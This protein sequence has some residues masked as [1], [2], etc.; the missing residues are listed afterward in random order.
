MQGIVDNVQWRNPHVY[1]TISGVSDSGEQAK[2]RIEAGPT[3]IMR[4]L[5]WDRDTLQAGDVIKVTAN[6]SRREGARSGYLVSVEAPG[7]VYPSLRGDDAM[8]RLAEG[9]STSAT[10]SSI[11]GTWTTV[12]N[13]EFYGKIF[14][15]E[16]LPLTEA[17]LASKESFDELTD[18]PGLDCIPNV[19][20]GMMWIPDIK[21]I[22]IDGDEI[23]IRGEFA[24]GERVIYLDPDAAP[25]GPTLHGR[26]VG[27]W[28]D[29]TLVVESDLFAHHRTG[30]V[31]SVASSPRKNVTETFR[32]NEDGKGLTYS[33]VM[34]DPVMLTEPISGEFQYVYRP[35]IEYESLPCD[36]DNSR[37]YLHD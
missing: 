22:R 29:D 1:F 4:R 16:Q 32:L 20:P 17:G 18:A 5:D 2:W 13:F 19:A 9:G 28:E 11:A 15:D 35:D 8:A 23:R 36:L 34:N 33:F 31:F 12:G 21:L 7:K 26:S 6:P 10:T 3:G 37:Q 24:N 27:R 25:T 14:D 30:V